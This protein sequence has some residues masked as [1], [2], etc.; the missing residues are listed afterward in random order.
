[1]ISCVVNANMV[2]I[3]VPSVLRLMA[4]L[5]RLNNLLMALSLSISLSLALSSFCLTSTNKSLVS[6]YGC[7]M[8]LL[9]WRCYS[10]TYDGLLILFVCC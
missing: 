1:M 10:F 3:G 5:S 4:T 9:Y 7:R 6:D 2:D 8:A